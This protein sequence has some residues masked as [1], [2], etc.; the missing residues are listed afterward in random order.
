MSN[1]TNAF[2]MRYFYQKCLE[3]EK[4]MKKK[5]RKPRDLHF[6]DGSV[7][8]IAVSEEGRPEIWIDTG[9][10][11]ITINCVEILKFSTWLT[12]VRKWA[13]GLK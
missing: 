6:D 5:P 13:V 2:Y 8:S 9:R 3:A 4:E 7:A 1:S 11:V 10:R 12:K